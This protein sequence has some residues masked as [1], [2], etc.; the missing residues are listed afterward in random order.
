[1][2]V[3]L[4]GAATR[5]QRQR[6]F[7]AAEASNGATSISGTAIPRIALVRRGGMRSTRSAGT[8]SAISPTGASPKRIQSQDTEAAHFDKPGDR[9]RRAYHQD[10]TT[11][12]QLALVVG[13][14][15]RSGV[16]QPQAQIGF[17]GTR[18]AAQQHRPPVDLDSGRMD[19]EA[20]VHGSPGRR[21]R[22]RA[23][24]TRPVRVAPVLG[25]DPAAMRLDDLLRDR[26]AEPGMRAEFLAGWSLGV[27]AVEDRSQLVLGDA[28][29]LILDPDENS[30]AV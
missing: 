6:N 28:R 7:A 17:S 2:A 29:A 21:I 30:T 3:T 1:M 16:N 13:D 22:N 4:L 25:P 24:P 27:E 23:P 15:T 14:Q 20:R 9:R 26:Q 10:I 5:T 8:S 12:R 18:G 11:P 19:Q